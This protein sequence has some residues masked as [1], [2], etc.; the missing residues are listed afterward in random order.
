MD[1]RQQPERHSGERP[2][3]RELSASD[4]AP[5]ATNVRLHG[6]PVPSRALGFSVGWR[7]PEVA[8]T[9]DDDTTP[10]VLAA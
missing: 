1:A 4:T 6:V 7:A 3:Q 9:E 8:V 5:V 2:H 10:A